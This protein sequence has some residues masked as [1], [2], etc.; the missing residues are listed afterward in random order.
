M[1]SDG[2]SKSFGIELGRREALAPFALSFS[3]PAGSDLDHGD[4][5]QMQEVG[6]ICIAGGQPE[7]VDLMADGMTTL[8]KPV[9][10][11][12]DEQVAGRLAS[13]GSR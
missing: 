4:H 1:P 8:F 5:G 10:I 9:I 2:G 6:F 7:P 12:F 3:I 11:I 13:R